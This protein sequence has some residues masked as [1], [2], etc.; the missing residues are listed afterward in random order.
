[1]PSHELDF[2]LSTRDPFT[3]FVCSEP[4]PTPGHEIRPA[5]GAHEPSDDS[6]IVKCGPVPFGQHYIVAE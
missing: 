3:H 4:F 2:N 1:M 6:T 5:S